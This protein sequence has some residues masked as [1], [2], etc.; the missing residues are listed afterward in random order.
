MGV[1]ARI[2]APP[3]AGATP[4]GGVFSPKLG[5]TSDERRPPRTDDE[6]IAR[7]D[8]V[9]I[10]TSAG[11]VDALQ[12]LAAD[13]PQNLAA[14]VFVVMHMPGYRP[15]ALPAILSWS[16]R[17]PI[18]KP[19]ENDEIQSGR[20]YVAPPDY[21]LLIE[22]NSRIALWHGPK[23]NNFRPAINPLFRSAADVYGRRV[24]G[25]ILTGTLDEGVAGLA[26]V[27]RHGGVTVVQDPSEAR[28]PEMPANALR[29]VAV[30][31][32]AP[33]RD[34]GRLLVK[35]VNG[36]DE[37]PDKTAERSL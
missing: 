11:G 34:I 10:G 3:C 24:V 20:I 4:A 13:L 7:R 6:L 26:W 33:I 30:D 23:E 36:L 28:F 21:H 35:L 5:Q 8:I 17:L 29:H 1:P 19:A 37:R 25:V 15:S 31:Y 32:V 9:V 14:S 22:R 27:K 16:A 12:T 2:D 18:V